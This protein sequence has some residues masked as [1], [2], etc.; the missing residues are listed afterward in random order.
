M[1]DMGK[2]TQVMGAVVDV[3]FEGGKLP[4]IMKTKRFI[5]KNFLRIE[6]FLIKLLNISL[7][8]SDSHFHI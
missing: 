3:S 8:S 4:K 5:N 7:H 1:S 2:V 6:K